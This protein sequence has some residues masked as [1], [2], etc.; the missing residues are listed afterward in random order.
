VSFA[1][2]SAPGNLRRPSRLKGIACAQRLDTARIAECG[3][4]LPE[5]DAVIIGGF[6]CRTRRAPVRCQRAIAMNRLQNLSAC[7]LFAA[8]MA[9]GSARASAPTLA[10]CLEA[11]DFIANAAVSRNNGISRQEFM[12][13]LESDLFTIHAFPPSLRWFA[14]DGDDEVFLTQSAAEVFDRPLDPDAQRGSFL[15]A[16][17]ERLSEGGGRSV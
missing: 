7:A 4:C 3:R 14:H 2:R 12:A 6:V 5:A 8:T 15:H 13:R 1:R 16:C 17:F 11:A 9:A 10:E